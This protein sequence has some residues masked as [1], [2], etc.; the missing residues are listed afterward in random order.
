MNP[1]MIAR[2]NG[3]GA[4]RTRAAFVSCALVLLAL[5]GATSAAAAPATGGAATTSTTTPTETAPP[6]PEAPATEAPTTESA[7]P[8]AKLTPAQ[9]RRL[10]LKLR[11]RPADGVIGPRTRAAIRRFQARHHLTAD[12]RPHLRVLTLLR[13]PVRSTTTAP[14]TT[15]AVPTTAT[16]PA[17]VQPAIEAAQSAIGAPYASGATGPSSFD[18]SGLMV[19]AFGQAG[20]TLPRTSFAQFETGTEVVL[21]EIQPGDLVFFDTDGAGAS[22]VGIALSAETAIS[23]TSH[24]VMEHPLT[25][26][27]WGEHLIGARRIG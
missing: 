8:V 17:G 1:L 4:R 22:H 18:C 6:A 16:A 21:T 9:V 7:E 20:I 27:Y 11:V 14:T 3:R 24:G 19:Y 12:G 10:Q 5:I 2:Q 25:T 15:T 13:I 23:A 26:G